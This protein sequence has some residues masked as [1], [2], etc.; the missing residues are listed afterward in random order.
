LAHPC[1]I[2]IYNLTHCKGKFFIKENWLKYLT[3]T[4]LLVWWL[5][6][7]SLVKN[8]RQGVF[9]TEGFCRKDLSILCKYLKQRWNIK[10]HIG[11]RGKYFQIRIYSTEE[12]KKFLRIIL[13]YFKV[14]NMLPKVILLYKDETL[15]QRWISEIVQLTGFKKS[16]VEKYL[17]IKKSKCK[18]FQKMI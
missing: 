11:K 5:D 13:P 12:L 16:V 3:S 18:K 17:E 10:A 15:Q 14:E 6:D 8:T 4:S 2:E 9:C 7:G 1:L